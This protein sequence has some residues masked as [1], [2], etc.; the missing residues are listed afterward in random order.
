MYFPRIIPRQHFLICSENNFSR[1][2]DF[3]TGVGVAEGG[4]AKAAYSGFLKA[5]RYSYSNMFLNGVVNAWMVYIVSITCN[6]CMLL[7]FM[8]SPLCLNLVSYLFKS[9]TRL[10]SIWHGVWFEIAWGRFWSQTF[11][12]LGDRPPSHV[13]LNSPFSIPLRFQFRI[14]LYVTFEFIF[15]N[16]LFIDDSK[17]ILI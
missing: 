3:R 1:T 10:C 6:S 15:I 14:H 16:N 8:V 9:C 12:R 13:W 2:L 17:S 7:R 4:N 5:D 11:F